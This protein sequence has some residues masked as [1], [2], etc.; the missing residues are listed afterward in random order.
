[1]NL[2]GKTVSISGGNGGITR[3]I[4]DKDVRVVDAGMDWE[5]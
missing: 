2:E 5:R 4:T 3:Q 1:M